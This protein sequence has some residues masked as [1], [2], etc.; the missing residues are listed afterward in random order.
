MTS[1]QLRAPGYPTDFRPPGNNDLKVPLNT[2]ARREF[3][4]V[5]GEFQW[6]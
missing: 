1:P 5:S 4:G 3:V 2:L 6:N